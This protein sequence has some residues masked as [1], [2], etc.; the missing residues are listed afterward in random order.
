MPVCP[1]P[2]GDNVGGGNISYPTDGD[3]GMGYVFSYFASG[4]EFILY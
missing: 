4:L 3:A 2:S 1:V